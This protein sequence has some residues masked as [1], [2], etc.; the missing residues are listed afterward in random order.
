MLAVKRTGR[1]LWHARSGCESFSLEKDRIAC[2]W[3]PME[4]VR[5]ETTVAPLGMWQ[6]RKHVI[7]ADCDAEAA[8]GAFAVKKDGPGKRPCDRIVTSLSQNERMAAA[9]GVYGSSAIFGIDG[10]DNGEVVH[11]EPNTNLMYPRTVIPMLR[12]RI[13][14]GRTVLLCAVWSDPE[15]C[16]PDTLPE[17]VL[18]Y[19]RSL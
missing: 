4:G 10:Y 16:C 7:D 9:H 17:E 1:D 6:I 14:P 18:R 15:D 2:C 3:S 19:A 13:R 8:E 5:I 11:A 12:A